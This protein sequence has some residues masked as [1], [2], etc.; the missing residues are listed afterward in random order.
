MRHF[1]EMYRELVVSQGGSVFS[2]WYF[3]C[4]VLVPVSV[5]VLLASNYADTVKAIENFISYLCGPTSD[6]SSGY[7]ASVFSVRDTVVRYS[8][9]VR[10]EGLTR[11][12][13]L[14]GFF[15]SCLNLVIQILT[16]FLFNSHLGNFKENS[17]RV[18]KFF[19]LRVDVIFCFLFFLFFSFWL[20]T[21]FGALLPH[22]SINLKLS[23][24]ESSVL[25]YFFYCFLGQY[26][27][28][29]SLSVW[30]VLWRSRV[31]TYSKG[32]NK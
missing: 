17:L 21:I 26:L 30:I 16:S 11:E 10:V 8:M 25:E 27:V 4:G 15:V 12:L 19:H 1:R 5:F 3:M 20:D 6:L 28:G 14:F 23:Q 29:I 32:V 24:R 7:C 31:E 22:D 18:E 9:A 13:M 2:F